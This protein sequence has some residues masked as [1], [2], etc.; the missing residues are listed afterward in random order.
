MVSQ[1]GG[2]SIDSDELEAL[3]NSLGQ[4]PSPAELE[5]MVEL[6]DADGS[7]DIDFIEFVTL[8]AHKMQDEDQEGEAD[9]DERLK[10]AFAIFVRAATRP[11]TPC[12]VPA[13]TRLPACIPSPL[14]GC[15]RLRA[16]RR[17]RDAPRDDQSSVI[18]LRTH[19]ASLHVVV[20]LGLR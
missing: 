3:M 18:A 19:E 6:A 14:T 16:N 1:D 17:R 9:E 2:G 11:T 15:G 13:A 20:S 5:K 4:Q 12:T 8:M 7:G 10:N